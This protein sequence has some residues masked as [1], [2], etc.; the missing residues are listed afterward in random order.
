MLK[1]FTLSL[2]I[3]SLFLFPFYI[4]FAQNNSIQVFAGFEISELMQNNFQNIGIN[5]F[6]IY[7]GLYIK[8]NSSYFSLNITSLIMN[9]DLSSNHLAQNSFIEGD[10]TGL[11]GKLKIFRMYYD[12]FTFLLDNSF[13]KISPTIGIG[14]GYTYMEISKVN[15]SYSYL[16]KAISINTFFRIRF[17]FFNIIFLELPSADISLNLWTNS[18]KI[19][20]LEN[21][22]IKFSDYF[23]IFLWISAGFV[24]KF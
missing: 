13:F 12:S 17:Y 1:N 8:N 14:L 19:K 18:D 11:Y 3:L 16:S 9:V 24:F 10:K 21:T 7:T 6:T 4:C 23:S 20:V 15:I 5:N 2:I 22:T